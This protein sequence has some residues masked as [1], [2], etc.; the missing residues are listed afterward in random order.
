M[1]VNLSGEIFMT[2]KQSPQPHAVERSDRKGNDPISSPK[3]VNP[4]S[5]L[6]EKDA[7]ERQEKGRPKQEKKK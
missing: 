5:T 1:I 3:N 7:Q 2:K 4:P 6:K